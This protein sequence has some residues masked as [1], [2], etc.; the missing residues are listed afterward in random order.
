MLED[1]EDDIALIEQVLKKEK[2]SFVCEHV[3]TRAEFLKSVTTFHP[4]VILSDHALPGFNSRE[5]LKISQREQPLT[6]FILVTGMMSD[7]YAIS[8]IHEGADDYV[9]KSNLSRL[10][11][12]IHAAVKRRK[13]ERLKRE[14]R[15]ALR[16][17]N[18]QLIKVNQ[19]LDNFVYS[20]SHNLRGPLA[21]VMGLLNIA[22]GLN[23]DQELTTL[24]NMMSSSV[25]K[26]DDT[27]REILDY[28]QNSRNDVH[29]EEIQWEELITMAFARLEYLYPVEAIIQPIQLNTDAPFFCDVSR[30][31]VVLNNLLSNAIH[32]RDTRRD[33]IIAIQVITS[34]K[35]ATIVVHDNGTGISDDV[36]PKVFDM[37]FRGTIL[38][39][40]AGLGLY[41]AKEIVARLNGQIHI[42]S[43]LGESTAVT[44]TIPNTL[45]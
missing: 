16:I 15:L 20:V 12:A 5:A 10:P 4:D 9:L 44:F 41:I 18:K 28:S 32:Y 21:S 6:P 14:A 23:K 19:E 39:K 45:P 34:A 33:L 24:H 35:E 7:E 1:S 8:C 13:L 29:L 17:Q 27:L 2:L 30:L 25:M 26:L 42:D 22:Q 40:G 36:L 37:F 31:T 11:T 43:V 38:S 3:D